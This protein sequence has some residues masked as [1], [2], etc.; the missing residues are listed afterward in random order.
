MLLQ[1]HI[2]SHFNNSIDK[3]KT[4]LIFLALTVLRDSFYD[5]VIITLEPLIAEKNGLGAIHIYEATDVF[6]D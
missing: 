4:Q 6:K 2:L 3:V 5:L 1:D